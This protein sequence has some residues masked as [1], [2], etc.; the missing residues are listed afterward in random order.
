[1]ERIGNFEYFD[2][3]IVASGDGLDTVKSN[4]VQVIGS[5]DLVV[6]MANDEASLWGTIG[7]AWSPVI[8]SSSG[9][10]AWK[11]SINEWR[12]QAVSFGGVILIQLL[13]VA[14]TCILY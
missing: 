13:K 2:Q 6:Y 5:A 12:P 1:M 14:F 11:T 4:A 9:S 10:N 3:K 7:I 8:C